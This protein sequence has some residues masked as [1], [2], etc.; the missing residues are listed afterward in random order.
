MTISEHDMAAMLDTL[1]AARADD[2]P[3]FQ[4]DVARAHLL[5]ALDQF[6]H[7]L[8]RSQ[9][10]A[11][12]KLDRQKR[13]RA[14]KA[15]A[16]HLR[17]AEGSLQSVLDRPGFSEPLRAVWQAASGEDAYREDVE[18]AARAAVENFA[19]WATAAEAAA[20]EATGAR[21][22]PSGSPAEDLVC[23]LAG[24]YLRHT[25][26]QPKLAEDPDRGDFLELLA[27]ADLA[28]RH[29]ANREGR[30]PHNG[31]LTSEGLRTALRTAMTRRDWQECLA[32][33]PDAE[34]S[35]DT[36]AGLLRDL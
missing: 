5:G 9:S 19:T 26:Q 11:L 35:A 32:W 3:P 16:G 17:A 30:E 7:G 27:R 20:E 33:T 29:A 14:F 1:G 13:Q 21:G 22:R 4:A 18:A 12:S 8:E 25:G 2:A 31:P 24:L 10:K 6:R 28:A 23:A 15:L 34:R 36:F